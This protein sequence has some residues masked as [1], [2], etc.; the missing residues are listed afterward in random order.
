[1]LNLPDIISF[2]NNLGFPIAITFYLL[3]RFEKKLE[4]LTQSIQQLTDT[5]NKNLGE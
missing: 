1:M 4:Y 2:I 5:I 3:Y